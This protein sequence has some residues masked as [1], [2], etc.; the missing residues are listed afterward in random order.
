M[1]VCSISDFEKS[2]CVCILFQSKKR[3]FFEFHE[4]TVIHTASRMEGAFDFFVFQ[5]CSRDVCVSVTNMIDTHNRTFDTIEQGECDVFFVTLILKR[6]E[7]EKET[8][9]SF[10]SYLVRH[11]KS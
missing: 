2:V 3:S 5:Q 4:S 10:P 9:P 1:C 11:K 6:I 7:T 8:W